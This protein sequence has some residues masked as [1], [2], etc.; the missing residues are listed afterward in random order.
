MKR[1]ETFGRGPGGVRRPGPTI[2]RSKI[3]RSL[4]SSAEG[5][6]ARLEKL[7]SGLWADFS[8]PVESGCDMSLHTWACI[9]FDPAGVSCQW[10]VVRCIELTWA[11][12]RFGV[13]SL[14]RGVTMR[15]RPRPVDSW[16]S[17]GETTTPNGMSTP[18]TEPGQPARAPRRS[19]QAFNPRSVMSPDNL[20]RLATKFS[21][22]GATL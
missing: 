11:L 21:I 13:L 20:G 19:V 5:W 1:M 10:S 2:G 18:G 6:R 22:V 7:K 15:C 14:S 4:R 8:R 9:I 3:D 17:P 12:A 16:E